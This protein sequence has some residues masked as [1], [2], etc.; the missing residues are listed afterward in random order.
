M[1]R[2]TERQK[3]KALE[4]YHEARNE[5]QS[6]ADAAQAAGVPY[7]TL[8][9]WERAGEVEEGKRKRP[10]GRPKLHV[11]RLTFPNGDTWS[12]PSLKNLLRELAKTAAAKV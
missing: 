7:I 5:G 11:Y 10:R 2:Y 6:S 4:K 1:K 3:E 8:R 9:T 12:D